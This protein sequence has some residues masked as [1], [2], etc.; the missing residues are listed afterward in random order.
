M[1]FAGYKSKPM[2]ILHLPDV[3][4]PE[5][6]AVPFPFSS[7]SIIFK[8]WA[9]TQKMCGFQRERWVKRMENQTFESATKFM[10]FVPKANFVL[11]G[12]TEHGR[13][14]G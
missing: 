5:C 6:L 4:C 1:A 11:G 2:V 10:D 9:K 7:G 8:E 14:G 12:F 3:Q 13:S